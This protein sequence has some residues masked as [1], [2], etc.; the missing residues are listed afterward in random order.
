TELTA[1]GKYMQHWWPEL[2]IWVSALVFFIAVNAINLINVRSYGE[3]E[4]WFALIKV[5]AVIAMILFGCY[6]L[7][8]GHGGPQAKV[9]NLWEYGGFF[10]KG[11]NGLLVALAIIMFS[12]GGLELVGIT[13]AEAEDPDKSI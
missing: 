7:F 11:Y 10:A 8:S 3:T 5:V 9:S 12:F 6:L 4:F 1:A 2:P 13:A